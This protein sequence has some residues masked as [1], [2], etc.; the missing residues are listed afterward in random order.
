MGRN[1]ELDNGT[2]EKESLELKKHFFIEV[3]KESF[4]ENKYSIDTVA[5]SIIKNERILNFSYEPTPYSFLEFLFM[6]YS[7]NDYDHFVDF[8]CGKG[9]TLI[10]ASEYSC[11]FITGYEI[12]DDIFNV[13]SENI[14]SHKNISNTISKFFIHNQDVAKASIDNT[15]NKFYFSNPFHLKIYIHVINSILASIKSVQRKIFLFLYMPHKTTI[16]YLKRIN[17]FHIV[18]SVDIQNNLPLYV[19]LANE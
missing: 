11:P 1:D 6:K 12:N 13:L 9:R 5:S 17:T 19:V 15:A 10:M 3:L 14:K 2:Y 18:E 16:E 4:Y 7:F 8:G